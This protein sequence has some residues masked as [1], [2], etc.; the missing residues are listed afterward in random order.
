MTRLRLTSAGQAGGQ[1]NFPPSLKLWRTRDFRLGKEVKVAA[2]VEMS[3][4]IQWTIKWTIKW[5]T[6]HE[7]GGRSPGQVAGL[8]PAQAGD[9]RVARLRPALACGILLSHASHLSIRHAVARLSPGD[10]HF[11]RNRRP[12]LVLRDGLHLLRPGRRP[13]ILKFWPQPEAFRR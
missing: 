11:A 3:W 6:G 2:E 7:P 10:G 13:Q 5:G 4:E 1:V 9:G 12:I 8:T